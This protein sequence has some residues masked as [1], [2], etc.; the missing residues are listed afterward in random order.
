MVAHRGLLD[1]QEETERGEGEEGREEVAVE[2]KYRNEQTGQSIDPFVLFRLHR[3]ADVRNA[4]LSVS[5]DGVVI[6][7]SPV[8]C[9]AWL[10]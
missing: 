4:V 2:T 9:Y 7:C 5:L 3:N 8:Y 6:T 10:R 1:G